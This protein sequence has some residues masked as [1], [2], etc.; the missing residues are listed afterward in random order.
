MNRLI[1]TSLTVLLTNFSKIAIQGV[2]L[3]EA[4]GQ[5]HHQ[6][7]GADKTTA[8]IKNFGPKHQKPPAQNHID[9]NA[10][11][12]RVPDSCTC[13]E[14]ALTKSLALLNEHS[15]PFKPAHD[16]DPPQTFTFFDPKEVNA[17]CGLAGET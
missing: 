11:A 10:L 15:G 7:T 9:S 6:T 16:G 17:E 13:E 14:I 1:K 2:P 3:N 4:I 5:L 8:F 12:D